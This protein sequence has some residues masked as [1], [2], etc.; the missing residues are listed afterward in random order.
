MIP[1]IRE[2]DLELGANLGKFRIVREVG[3]GGMG[4]VYEAVDTTLDRRV[5]LKVLLQPAAPGQEERERFLREAAL[6][7]K[8]R[9]PHIVSVHEA[10]VA[11]DL[12]FFTMDFV[13]GTTLDR[14]IDSGEIDLRTLVEILRKTASAVQAAHEASII[15][16]DLKPANVILD[17]R[18]EPHVTDFGL[19]KDL[20][21]P[22]VLTLSGTAV[23]TPCYMSPEQASGVRG[24]V[25]AQ[26][27]VYS[28]GVMLYQGLT[29]KLPFYD[30]SLPAILV[31]VTM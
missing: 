11:E 31:K 16:R 17:D 3:R 25:D 19:A 4:V 13:D 2:G 10:G 30:E 18:L 9:H 7:A 29:R 20:R 21:S 14:K 6:A 15:H 27:D 23:G 24:A 26:S 1:A 22:G 8:L 28:L 12:P 5:A